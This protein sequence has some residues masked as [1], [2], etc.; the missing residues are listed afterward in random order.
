V[1]LDL[2]I[3][4][5]ADRSPEYLRRVRSTISGYTSV[6]FAEDVELSMRAARQASSS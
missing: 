1:L 2:I 4:D 5:N 3:A 6:P